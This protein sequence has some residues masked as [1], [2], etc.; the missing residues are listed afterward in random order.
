MDKKK[1]RRT[2]GQRKKQRVRLRWDRIF[3]VIILPIALIVFAIISIRGCDGPADEP[4]PV[5]FDAPTCVPQPSQLDEPANE[6]TTTIITTI[7]QPIAPKPLPN[8]RDVAESDAAAVTSH[9][10]GS[11]ARQNSLLNIHARHSALR[12]HGFN[13]AA[14]EYI[15]TINKYLTEHGIN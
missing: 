6:D 13:A 4:R 7:D 11:M 1:T 9:R 12:R 3:L 8:V 10:E 2:S 5:E 15:N 14:D